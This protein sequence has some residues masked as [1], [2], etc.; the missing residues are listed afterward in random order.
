VTVYDRGLRPG[1]PSH[2]GEPIA[3]DI[4]FIVYNELN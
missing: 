1:G 2:T 3:V 4:G